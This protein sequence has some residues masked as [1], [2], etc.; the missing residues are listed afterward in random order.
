MGSG[1]RSRRQ[2]GCVYERPAFGID[3][4]PEWIAALGN[5]CD[6]LLRQ[7]F[8]PASHAPIVDARRF[9]NLW[10]LELRL[11]R[12]FV[13]TELRRLQPLADRFHQGPQTRLRVTD[14]IFVHHAAAAVRVGGR[15]RQ[16]RPGVPLVQIDPRVE[17]RWKRL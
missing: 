13:E 11:M 8:A 7:Q 6:L 16:A 4:P 14:E 10:I 9:S 1:A 17:I 12:K 2:A 3:L 15:E 5:P